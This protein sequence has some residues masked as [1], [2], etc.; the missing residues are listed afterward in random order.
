MRLPILKQERDTNE[1]SFHPYYTEP[2]E[3]EEEGEPFFFLVP[4]KH[5]VQNL[6]RLKDL[7]APNK[8]EVLAEFDNTLPTEQT[9][10]H[11]KSN[12]RKSLT[13]TAMV[14]DAVQQIYASVDIDGVQLTQAGEVVKVTRSGKPAGG[15]PAQ[16]AEA[17]E[18][19]R[20]LI[21]VQKDHKELIDALMDFRER[22]NQLLAG[23]AR[24]DRK[25][26]IALEGDVKPEKVPSVSRG[27]GRPP[28]AL[29]PENTGQVAALQKTIAALRK[30]LKESQKTAPSQSADTVSRES[31]NEALRSRDDNLSQLTRQLKKVQE[32]LEYQKDQ[33]KSLRAELNAKDELASERVKRVKAEA[34]MR[35]MAMTMQAHAGGSSFN[36]SQFMN[37]TFSECSPIPGTQQRSPQQP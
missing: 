23:G 8:N 34:G 25:Y 11:L 15:V 16:N 28:K 17:A 27:R 13:P 6:G 36:V 18:M 12:Y 14:D 21:K 31:H 32:E 26:F 22:Y 33:V 2:E 24:Y 1:L 5:A 20:K 30:E 10:K 29:K 4:G 37:S 3:G 7:D 9:T 19:N 35:A